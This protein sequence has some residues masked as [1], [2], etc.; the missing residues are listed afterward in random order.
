MIK[1]ESIKNFTSNENIDELSKNIYQ[2]TD[3]LCKHYPRHRE[4]YFSTQL[5]ES[6]NSDKRNILFVRDENNKDK[7]IAMSCLKNDNEKKICTLYVL[8]EYRNKGIGTKLI[9]E[10]MNWLG[11]TKPFATIANDNLKELIPI[12]KKYNWELVEVLNNVYND[13]SHE[14]CFNGSLTKNIDETKKY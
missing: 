12:I 10:S 5:P 1:I 7:I 4:W 2:I 11:T 3:H 6:I 14:L 8:P 9:E 13:F